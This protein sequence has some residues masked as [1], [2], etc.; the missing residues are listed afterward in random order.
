MNLLRKYL[1]YIAFTLLAFPSLVF[2]GTCPSGA[3]YTN[4]AIPIGALVTLS[5]LGVINCFYISSAGAD[6]NAGTVESPSG[7][8]LHAP[9]MPGCSA[10][11]SSTTPVAGMGFIFRG[12]DT[13]HFGN[14]AASPYVGGTWTWTRSGSSGSPIYIGVDQ[15]WYSGGSWSRPIMNGDNPLSTSAVASCAYQTGSGNVFL[16]TAVVHYVKTESSD[17][18]CTTD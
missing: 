10:V 18:V 2:G 1:I 11:C 8:W 4:P 16:S 9:G 7:S 3:N 12:G 6:T 5:S 14:S 15:T 13:W 17:Q